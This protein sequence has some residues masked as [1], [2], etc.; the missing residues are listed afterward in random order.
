MM[1][2]VASMWLE[3]ETLES[4]SIFGEQ[5]DYLF[6]LVNRDQIPWEFGG[7]CHCRGDLPC[8]PLPTGGKITAKECEQLR[9]NCKWDPSTFLPAGYSTGVL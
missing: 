9:R 5:F 3:P 7:D 6:E 1:F 4:F 2:R 8:I